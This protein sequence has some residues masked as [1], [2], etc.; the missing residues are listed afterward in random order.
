MINIH[1]GA[2]P[3]FIDGAECRAV[4]GNTAEQI[5]SFPD[6]IQGVT[7]SRVAG[8]SNIREPL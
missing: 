4:L 7:V 8:C 1:T 5:P 3:V 2:F 6:F